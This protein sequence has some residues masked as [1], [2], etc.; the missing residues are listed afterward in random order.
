MVVNIAKKIANS[1]QSEKQQGYFDKL[2]LKVLDNIIVK[3]EDVHVRLE[4]EVN[5][6]QDVEKSSANYGQTTFGLL[7]SSL[8]VQT[9]DKN[10]A[11]VFHDRTTTTSNIIKVLKLEGLAIY[12]NPQ[13]PLIIHQLALEGEDRATQIT[14]MQALMDK[15]VTP[16][17][18]RVRVERAERMDNPYDASYQN[19]EE[20]K[21]M[22]QDDFLNYI[23][24]PSKCANSTNHL[25]LSYSDPQ[26]QTGKRANSS[27]ENQCLSYA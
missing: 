5:A 8:E 6:T 25:I 23:L 10:G 13:D 12:L 20:I 21:A 27:V 14:R 19:L 9:V 7:L 2:K 22:G 17:R 11:P 26:P 15:V 18:N 16:Y 24:Q 1:I 3:I 4:E